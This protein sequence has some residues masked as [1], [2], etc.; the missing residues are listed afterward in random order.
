MREELLRM[1]RRMLSSILRGRILLSDDS[2]PMQLLQIKLNDLETIDS[3]PRMID[4]G[5]TSRLPAESDVLGVFIGGDRSNAA[6][7]GTNHAASRPRSLEEGESALYNQIG[8]RIYLSNGG[9][10]IE[11]AGLPL[12][13]NNTPVVTINA[14]TKVEMNTTALNV[15]GSIT[16]GGDI[17]DNASSAG[18]SMAN[19]R[20]VY[21]GHGHPVPNVQPGS[22]TVTSNQPNQ[23]A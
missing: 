18:K 1:A 23:P 2:G 20:L 9:L 4:F 13:I 3:V 22:A 10:V 16:A 15:T 8:I 7:L 14:S 6:I 17:T 19:M 5:F 12:T 11:G 21:N